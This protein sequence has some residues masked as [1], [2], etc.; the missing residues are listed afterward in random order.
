MTILL[1]PAA[2]A[3]DGFIDFPEF[4]APIQEVSLEDLAPFKS[5]IATQKN[6]E[7]R[8]S[9]FLQA[10][11]FKKSVP[12]K[13]FLLGD[14]CSAVLVANS[15]YAVTALHCLEPYYRM[16]T[17]K[18]NF[19]S[20]AT[21]LAS[22]FAGQTPTS[23]SVPFELILAGKGYLHMKPAVDDKILS[24]LG[25]IE[26]AREFN[27]DFAIIKMNKIPQGAECARLGSKPFTPNGLIWT[28]GYPK[29]VKKATHPSTVVYDVGAD[30]ENTT[31]GQS[32]GR[33]AKELANAIYDRMPED[34][35]TKHNDL[36]ANPLYLS[37][38]RAYDSY[39]NLQ[40]KFIIPMDSAL[41]RDALYPLN[42]H[43]V[44]TTISGSRM[45]GG[46][47]FNANGQLIGIAVAKA[48]AHGKWYGQGLAPLTTHVK[49]SYVFER[50]KSMLGAQRVNEI[51]NCTEI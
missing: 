22:K 24:D 19:S 38:G 7:N 2:K 40:K 14:H 32:L 41:N 35:R 37:V 6:L 16:N 39:R 49:T 43:F 45:S 1:Q 27:D 4:A 21:L 33:A 12:R 26:N 11:N 36:M 5:Q 28:A 29:Y 20:G 25:T 17:E 15:G 3:G 46:G 51:F 42:R 30:L 23:V 44:S 18:F 47:T 48:T 13:V 9:I 50:A 8:S 31:W 34:V 10:E